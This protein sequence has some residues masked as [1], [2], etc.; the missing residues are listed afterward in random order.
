MDPVF[1][2]GAVGEKEGLRIG[3]FLYL[4]TGYSW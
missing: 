4:Q 2:I 1:A 3:L